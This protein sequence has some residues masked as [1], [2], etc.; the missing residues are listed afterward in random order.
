MLELTLKIG[1]SI[2]L[3]FILYVQISTHLS[4]G[5]IFLILNPK[6]NLF[7]FSN[8]VFDKK[9]KKLKAVIQ[10]FEEK[11]FSMLKQRKNFPYGQTCNYAHEHLQSV[12]KKT[13]FLFID[14]RNP[15]RIRVIVRYLLWDKIPLYI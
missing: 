3:H 15:S 7:S 6:A 9:T 12:N 8:N 1:S 13:Q 14:A 11:I 2:R 5:I 10:I 4:E